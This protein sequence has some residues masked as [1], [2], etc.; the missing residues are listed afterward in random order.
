VKKKDWHR[1]KSQQTGNLQVDE[2][3]KLDESVVVDHSDLVVTQVELFELGQ[4]AKP[5]FGYVAQMISAQITA[6]ETKRVSAVYAPTA[7]RR[8]RTD[9]HRRG[10][11]ARP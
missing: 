6:N 7:A 4:T 3:G 5:S 10:R 11:P 2:A 1:I 9:K 8:A